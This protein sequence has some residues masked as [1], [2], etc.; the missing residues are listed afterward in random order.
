[1][2]DARRNRF[3]V[4]VIRYGEFN[5]PAIVRK[6]PGWENRERQL[7]FWRFVCVL[8]LFSAEAVES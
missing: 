8:H 3:E 7:E 6:G 2:E 1:M 5:E 4:R